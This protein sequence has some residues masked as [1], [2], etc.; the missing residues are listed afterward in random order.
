[1][2]FWDI[3]DKNRNKTGKLFRRDIDKF[4]EGEYHIVVAALILN[5]KKQIL[6]TKRA[7]TKKKFAGLWEFTGGSVLSGETSLDGILREVREEIGLKFTKEDAI[8]FKTF[9]TDRASFKDVWLFKTDIEI[10]DLNFTD[11]EVEDA[12]WVTIQE[13]LEMRKKG[14]IIPTIDIEEEEY[15]SAINMI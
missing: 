12:K 11:K 15:N 1:M 2:E 14:E 6:I 9:M 8:F 4:E 3:Y 5:S 7:Q 10:K 13:F